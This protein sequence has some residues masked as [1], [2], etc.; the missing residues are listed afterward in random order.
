[1]KTR[2]KLLEEAIKAKDKAQIELIRIQAIQEEEKV[3]K[4]TLTILVVMITILV[5]EAIL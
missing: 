4:K 1:M 5:F 3:L 2:F